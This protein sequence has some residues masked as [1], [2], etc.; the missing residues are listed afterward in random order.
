M[1]NGRK[2]FPAGLKFLANDDFKLIADLCC[3]DGKFL[4]MCCDNLKNVIP[5]ASDLSKISVQS[6]S[7]RFLSENK[8]AL[9]GI[10][11]DVL[12]VQK[13]SQP[14]KLLADQNY[15]KEDKI[16]LC[17]WYLLHEISHHDPENVVNLLQQINSVFPSAKILIGEIINI[18][19]D[20][21]SKNKYSS[22]MPEFTL[23]HD[24]SGQGLLSWDQYQYILSKIPFELQEE[25]ILDMVTL[26]DGSKSPSAFVW[27]LSPVST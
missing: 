21:L 20:V 8:V 23:F 12:D 13:W 2:F 18:P 25:E 14:V 16:V 7:E 11:S 19:Q 3:G 9:N 17:F 27:L 5:F 26:K 22:I 1:T 24:L 4:S 15:L 6:A 10:V